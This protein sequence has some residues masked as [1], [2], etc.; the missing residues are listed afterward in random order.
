[1]ILQSKEVRLEAVKSLTSLY[2][3]D[4][5]IGSMQHFTERF[6]P[7][8][9]EIA[10][11]EY[12]I[13]VRVAAIHT[14]RAIDKHGLLEDEQRDEVGRLV[15]D[16]E[17]RVRKAVGEFC[18]ALLEE[19]VENR[20][21]EM[22]DLPETGEETARARE[23][24]AKLE[25]HLAL[26]SLAAMLVKF[27]EQVDSKSRKGRGGSEDPE[28]DDEK[29]GD[30]ASSLLSGS[31][32]TESS[33]R[34]GDG[35]ASL[36]QVSAILQS[37]QKDRVSSAVEGLWNGVKVVQDWEGMLEFLLLDH[38]STRR[39]DGSD[40][41]RN[42]KST[43][44]TGGA[45]QPAGTEGDAQDDDME[46]EQSGKEDQ[47]L[48]EVCRLN[49]AEETLLLNVFA[50]SVGTTRRRA[51]LLKDDEA[52]D[53]VESTLTRTL[54]NCLPRLLAKHQSDAGRT[55]ILLVLPQH[56]KLSLYLDLRSINAYEALWD[57]VSKQFLAS[58]DALLLERSMATI[59]YFKG[60]EELS[61]TN[62]EKT[63]ELQNAVV[64]PLFEAS[65][66]VDVETAGLDDETR[67]KI[68]NA[69][70]RLVLL[71]KNWDVSKML[72]EKADEN[73][74][75]VL[76]AVTSVSERGSLGYRED[77]KVSPV[78]VLR[79]SLKAGLPC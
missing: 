37:Q 38:S 10:T 42:A 53:E 27:G 47:P 43:A 57:D 61:R 35:A 73:Q 48:D 44:P 58:T 69:L 26:K 11:S 5:Y 66:T 79:Q 40:K 2:A 41:G 51:S 74:Q 17:P 28:Q 9:V 60:T 55:F 78:D 63:A 72:D 14:L 15:Y 6:K 45:T 67:G 70:G 31:T 7:R 30:E 22:A 49:D 18:E 33:I 13:A 71:G 54:M 76:S 29:D 4:N 21:V 68:G 50:A 16:A 1:M 75:S 12:E 62:A 46:A 36:S 39:S 19:D 32:C 23:Q 52:R 64:V 20:K 8:L 34:Q 25:K 3:K 77:E 56:M 24:A 65:K 59:M